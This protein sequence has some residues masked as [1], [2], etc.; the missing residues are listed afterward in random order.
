M[1][2]VSIL[3]SVSMLRWL[4]I[5]TE[6]QEVSSQTG[7]TKAIK[8]GVVVSVDEAKACRTTFLMSPRS[9]SVF[10]VHDPASRYLKASWS[11]PKAESSGYAVQ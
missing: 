3:M 7:S 10:A 2:P 4:R 1:C 9:Y 11:A 6:Y 5:A 8:K